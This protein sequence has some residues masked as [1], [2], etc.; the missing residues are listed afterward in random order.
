MPR[1]VV[2]VQDQLGHAHRHDAA[3]QG[4]VRSGAG[5]DDG[6]GRRHCGGVGRKG[7]RAT[8]ATSSTW[9]PVLKPWPPLGLRCRGQGVLN[10][11]S[12]EGRGRIQVCGV[13]VNFATR[14]VALIS[15]VTAQARRDLALTPS[16]FLLSSTMNGA[17]PGEGLMDLIR[18]GT[19]S[20]DGRQWGWQDD[21]PGAGVAVVG[22]GV[23]LLAW[24]WVEDGST[25]TGL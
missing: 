21:E 2:R 5:H 18:S 25:R 7:E 20:G 3:V 24:P 13:W 22:P 19:S 16:V 15:A 11:T 1:G 17:S 10:R 8:W 6:P 12:D 14:A 23:V 4:C 9:A